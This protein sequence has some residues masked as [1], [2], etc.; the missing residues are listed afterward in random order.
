VLTI[1]RPLGV[2]ITEDSE[3][4]LGHAVAVTGG[5]FAGIRP[6]DKRLAESGERAR[7]RL[8]DGVLGPGR[9]EPDA[10]DL[11]EAAYWP[12]PRESGLLGADPL[13]GDALAALEMTDIRWG[14]SARRGVQRLLA[15]GTV[16]LAG[17]FTRPA[18]RT[19]VARSGV[20]VY[21]ALPLS[22][23]R[24]ALVL[25]AVADCTVSAPD[26]GCLVTVIDGRI[27]FRAQ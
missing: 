10:V 22:K 25:S 23:T 19:A 2:R 18:V 24:R 1:H 13:T 14:A 9:Y 7:V 20:R 3:P 11:L 21:P 26:G 5:R 12:D 16:V 17:P 6:Y 15:R 4:V 8:W 27:L